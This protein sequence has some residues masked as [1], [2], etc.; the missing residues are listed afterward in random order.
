MLFSEAVTLG[1]TGVLGSAG[2]RAAFY[3]LQLTESA[4]AEK[5]HDGLVGFFGA[6]AQAL[7]AS[8]LRELYSRIGSPFDSDVSMTFSGFV[9][10]AKRMHSKRSSGP[11]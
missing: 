5:V 8:I 2:A 10:E 11:T 4:D 1:L 7:E 6:G 9:T 3:H